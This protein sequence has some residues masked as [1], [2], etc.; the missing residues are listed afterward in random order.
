MALFNQA[1]LA[2]QSWRI[3]N[4]EGSLMSRVLK[5]KYFPNCTFWEAKLNTNVSFTWRSILGARKVIEKGARRVVGDGAT[6]SIWGDPWVPHLPNFRV[7]ERPRKEE[8]A[9]TVVKELWKDREWDNET[10]ERWFLQTEVAAIRRVPVP[11]FDEMDTWCWHYSKDGRFTVRSAYRMLLTKEVTS[12]A[13]SSTTRGRFDWNLIWDATV[14]PKIKHFA[15]RAV[16]EGLAVQGQ[17]VKRGLGGEVR[18]KVCGE[19]VETV[20][21]AQATCPDAQRIWRYT[22]VRV[23]VDDTKEGS[24]REWCVELQQIHKE[25]EWWSLFWSL[26][27]GIW[28]RRNGWVFESRKRPVE[29]IIHRATRLVGEYLTAGE[30]TGTDRCSAQLQSKW[31]APLENAYK[32]NADG[33]IFKG[34]GVGMGGVTRDGVGDVVA[35]TCAFLSG[36]FEVAV[37][38]A[39]AVRHALK[40]SMEAGFSEFV[41]EMDNMEVYQKLKKC[42]SEPTV[43]GRILGD[44]HKLARMC[45]KVSFSFVKRE[46]N[47]VAHLLAKLSCNFD[48]VRVWLEDV[49]PEAMAAVLADVAVS[50]H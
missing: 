35:S 18:S 9:P 17:L 8:E 16:R 24:F 45:R 6:T 42:S 23:L 43:L 28:L 29:A 36:S 31:T 47:G 13:S 15:S 2:K 10:L 32:I 3:V 5:G 20:L 21:H 40:T 19:G 22:P 26:C 4:N 30:E 44:I 33:A 49:P 50:S 1:L 46:G 37:V 48:G 41:V 39:M 7:S 14:P 11:M 27:W 38:E 25:K 12:R 34:R